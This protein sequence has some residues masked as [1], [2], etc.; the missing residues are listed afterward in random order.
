ML[1]PISLHN[2]NPNMVRYECSESNCAEQQTAI[3]STPD[4]NEIK[5]R[6]RQL[7]LEGRLGLPTVQQLAM[8][9]MPQYAERVPVIR[10]TLLR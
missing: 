6:L 9:W 2:H 1:M 5:D 10:S 8:H 4:S 3:R 7:T